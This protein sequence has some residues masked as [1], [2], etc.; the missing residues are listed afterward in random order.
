MRSAVNNEFKGDLTFVLLSIFIVLELSTKRDW[1]VSPFLLLGLTTI[2]WVWVLIS[3]FGYG[4]GNIG[5]HISCQ[6]TKPNVYSVWVNSLIFS[7]SQS[8]CGTDPFPELY[9][10]KKY[11]LND[12][13]FT[14]KDFTHIMLNLPVQVT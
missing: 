4:L 5:S 10:A 13:F 9:R 2:L 14:K 7:H 8:L 1:T 11:K 12:H 6:Y 3:I